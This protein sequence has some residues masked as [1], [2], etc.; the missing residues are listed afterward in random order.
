MSHMPSFLS[1]WKCYMES[2][3][4]KT[5]KMGEISY[6]SLHRFTILLASLNAFWQSPA[7]SRCHSVPP[8]SDPLPLSLSTQTRSLSPVHSP[9]SSHRKSFPQL[10]A[11]VQ[12]SPAWQACSSQRFP[13]QR[14]PANPAGCTSVRYRCWVIQERNT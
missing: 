6:F 8:M 14:C 12:V 9:V 11:L 10:G 7:H 4:E 3:S 13:T 2:K 5:P 1:K